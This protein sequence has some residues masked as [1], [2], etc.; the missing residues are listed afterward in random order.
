MQVW[1]WAIALVVGMTGVGW[2]YAERALLERLVGVHTAFLG[3]SLMRYAIPMTPGSMKD[4]FFDIDQT[5]RVGVSS[6][7]ETQLLGLADAAVESG[8][9]TLFIEVNPIVARF[10]GDTVGCGA[11]NWGRSVRWMART[12]VRAQIS[13]VDPW[14]EATD[15]LGESVQSLGD[16]RFVAERYPL[17]FPAPCHMAKWQALVAKAGATR[18]TLIAMPRAAIA[19]EAIG[20]V[21]MAQFHQSAQIFASQLGLPLFVVDPQGV[22][23]DDRFVDAAHMTLRG[24]DAFMKELG[25]WWAGQQ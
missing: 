7:S 24:A 1:L 12:A 20:A 23:T 19:R 4:S 2:W 5:L 10:A 25:R 14:G 3:S 15:P 17:H 11:R 22:W 21:D 9:K 16:G 6:V 8:V 13:G 18:I